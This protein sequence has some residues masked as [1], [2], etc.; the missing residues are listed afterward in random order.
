M[1][2]AEYLTGAGIKEYPLRRSC[3]DCPPSPELEFPKGKFARVN[4]TAII[5]INN[6]PV[7]LVRIHRV[8]SLKGFKYGSL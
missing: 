3:G 6:H 5:N 4:P 8:S 2:E 1:S 7:E